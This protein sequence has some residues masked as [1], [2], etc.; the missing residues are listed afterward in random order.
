MRVFLPPISFIL[1]FPLKKLLNKTSKLPFFSLSLLSSSNHHIQTTS[2]YLTK[3]IILLNCQKIRISEKLNLNTIL[4][5]LKESSLFG[6]STIHGQWLFIIIIIIFFYGNG[7]WHFAPYEFARQNKEIIEIPPSRI[8]S[9]IFARS[10]TPDVPFAPLEE[11]KV[12]CNTKNSSS[13]QKKKK[14]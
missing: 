1:F 13:K 9:V 12:Q 14:S 2:K 4:F 8:P 11:G 5:P 7:Q 3:K 6:E 10:G